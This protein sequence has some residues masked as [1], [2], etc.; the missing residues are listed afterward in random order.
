MLVLYD[1]IYSPNRVGDNLKRDIGLY[2]HIPFC[3][4][5]CYYCN[6]ASYDKKDNYISD[7][8]NS[9]ISEILSNIEILSNSNITSIYIGGGTPSYIDAKYIKQIIDVLS[10]F[11]SDK[12]NLEI[13]IEVNPGTVDKEKLKLYKEIGINRLSIG[14]Q[15]IYDDILK[16]I[17]R[18]HTIFDFNNTLELASDV[19][20]NNI[21]VDL[22]YPLPALTFDRFKDTIEYILSLDIIKHISVYNLEVNEGSK[23]EFL[24]NNGYLTIVDEDEEYKMYEY[25]H[26][27][28]ANNNYKQYEI[29]NYSKNGYES[30]HN[31][32][33]WH[34]GE[35]LGF[36]SSASSFI[37][38]TRYTNVYDVCEYISKIKSSLSTI[39]SK[40]SLDKLGL[41]KE[42]VILNLRL[43]R[44][45]NIL[46]FK[47]KYDTD[48]FDMFGVEFNKLKNN[49]LL[50][51]KNKNIYLTRRG[52][53]VANLVWQEFI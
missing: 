18:I 6:F 27:T 16:S 13:T 38:G 48:I 24:L 45:I 22:M 7:Y 20:F 32:N 30:K 14:L 36:G 8:I 39:V 26:N 21:S 29:S 43:D 46:E 49:G 40:E 25:L 4:S 35:Y 34:Q 15:S 2:I 5:K 47:K 17:G 52:K 44:G 41:M 42:Y 37:D 19:G 31:I 11:L 23:L 33:Y 3:K 51:Y 12:E 28:L 10:L 50:E 53:E 1:I 9:L